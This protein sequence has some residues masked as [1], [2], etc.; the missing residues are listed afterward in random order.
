MVSKGDKRH[1]EHVKDCA[2]FNLTSEQSALIKRATGVT[3]G[4]ISLIELSGPSASA[5]HP[6]LLKAI[7]VVACW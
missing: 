6:G 2:T 1:D 7:S 5:L 4:E 3:V